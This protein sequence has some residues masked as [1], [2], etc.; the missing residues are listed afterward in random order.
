[1]MGGVTSLDSA[2]KGGETGGLIG[3]PLIF[4]AAVRFFSL[5]TMDPA[6]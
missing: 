4:L 2:W 5:D 1:M 6:S 3:N